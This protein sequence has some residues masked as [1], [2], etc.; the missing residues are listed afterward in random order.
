MTHLRCSSGAYQQSLPI[1]NEKSINFVILIFLPSDELGINLLAQ[2]HFNNLLRQPV[3]KLEVGQ[4]ASKNH[5]DA[6]WLHFRVHG[7]ESFY[8]A[9]EVYQQV[10]DL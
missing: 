6:L 3:P 9:V 8:A 2:L 10:Q 7:Y 1:T 5:L 4:V